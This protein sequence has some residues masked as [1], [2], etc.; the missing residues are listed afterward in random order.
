MLLGSLLQLKF[1]HLNSIYEEFLI[2]IYGF[3]NKDLVGHFFFDFQYFSLVFQ[4]LYCHS[5]DI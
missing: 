5:G 3:Q 2:L 1:F 4:N